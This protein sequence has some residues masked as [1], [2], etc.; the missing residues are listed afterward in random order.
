MT[1]EHSHHLLKTVLNTVTT[2]SPQSKLGHVDRT[3]SRGGGGGDHG[4]GRRHSRRRCESEF[5]TVPYGDNPWNDTRT[6]FPLITQHPI[7]D[8]DVGVVWTMVLEVVWMVSS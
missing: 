3:N 4:L 5:E 8:V 1:S 7:V 2:Q 6:M